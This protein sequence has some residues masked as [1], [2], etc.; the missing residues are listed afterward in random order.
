MVQSNGFCFWVH[1][2]ETIQIRRFIIQEYRYIR[3]QEYKKEKEFEKG[4]WAKL[5]KRLHIL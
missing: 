5:Q 1:S 4:I 2:P 3:K